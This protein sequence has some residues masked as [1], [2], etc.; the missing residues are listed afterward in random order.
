MTSDEV[1]LM[2]MVVFG[3]AINNLPPG[4]TSEQVHAH[5]R[6]TLGDSAKGTF[7][8]KMKDE[9]EVPEGEVATPVTTA[10]CNFTRLEDAQRC[11]ERMAV[12]PLCGQLL[13]ARLQRRTWQ[14][15]IPGLAAWLGQHGSEQ[16]A[17]SAA[18]ALC[19]EPSQSAEAAAQSS[20]LLQRSL[21]SYA[22]PAAA[23]GVRELHTT[24][25]STLSR[26]AE[27]ENENGTEERWLLERWREGDLDERSVGVVANRTDWLPYQLEDLSAPSVWQLTAPVRAFCYAVLLRAP[28]NADQ[29][30]P[31]DKSEAA[32]EGGEGL[33]VT[34][35][36]TRKSS[37]ARRPSWVLPTGGRTP[38]LAQLGEMEREEKEA[39]LLCMLGE[40]EPKAV[41]G[42]LAQ[43][44]PQL[45]LVVLGMRY[46]LRR[47]DLDG[48]K[49]SW[50]ATA[51]AIAA[52]LGSV[53]QRYSR[54]ESPKLPTLDK[55]E[56]EE[57]SGC[58]D[59]RSAHALASWQA[60]TCDIGWL[61]ALLGSPLRPT[62]LRSTLHGSGFHALHRSLCGSAG[63][64]PS[65]GRVWEQLEQEGDVAT[66]ALAVLLRASISGLE[67][68]LDE[69]TL[70]ALCTD[71]LTVQAM[72]QRVLTEDIKPV[73]V[74][75]TRPSPPRMEGPNQQGPSSPQSPELESYW[76]EWEASGGFGMAVGQGQPRQQPPPSPNQMPQFWQ[77]QQ[78]AHAQAQ[79]MFA[80][81]QQQQQHQQQQHQQQQMFAWQQQQQQQQAPQ[82]QQQQQQQAA[83]A[84]EQQQRMQF[85][86]MQHQGKLHIHASRA[87]PKSSVSETEPRWLCAQQQWARPRRRRWVRPRRLSSSSRCRCRCSTCT[88]NTWRP[89]SSRR[90]HSRRSRSSTGRSRRRR[91]APPHRPAAPKALPMPR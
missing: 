72:D 14:C 25:G 59:P 41:A 51:P 35:W 11:V 68:S 63:A 10:F 53:A 28:H 37:V 20:A 21:A 43:V 89:C 76:Q 55:W 67:G 61:N 90:R 32:A 85:A 26:G 62:P 80:W 9:E 91:P 8:V 49:L 23:A 31:T 54:T 75:G 47:S 27:S 82:Q 34:E 64:S 19:A 6:A 69:P 30:A 33:D 50:A 77:Q 88:C 45:H 81:Q 74:Q 44:S 70:R 3:I 5:V 84:F 1:R 71:H 36:D 66:N 22:L 38:D 78:Q 65:V 86:Q 79:Q 57:T 58:V 40:P 29:A 87:A 13:S 18:V 16:S 12:L 39:L 15:I 48:C 2:D 42:L 60:L 17:L 4:M 46:W 83:W 56:K 24:R 52:V 73:P 7:D